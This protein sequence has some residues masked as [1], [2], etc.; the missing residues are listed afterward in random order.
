VNESG[1]IG[2]A[3]DCACTGYFTVGANGINA[4]SFREFDSSDTYFTFSPGG[5]QVA[6]RPQGCSGMPAWT[7]TP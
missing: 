2:G 1:G 7:S 4:T 3:L 6:T 5:T